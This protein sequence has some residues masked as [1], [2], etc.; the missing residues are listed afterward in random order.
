MSKSLAE[1]IAELEDSVAQSRATQA[2]WTQIE[3]MLSVEGTD[4]MKIMEKVREDTGTDIRPFLTP[5]KE[6]DE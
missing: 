6:R 5:R 2:Y 4:K 1:S 3:L